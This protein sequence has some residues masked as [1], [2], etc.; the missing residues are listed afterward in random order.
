MIIPHADRATVDIRK[1]REY[2]LDPLHDEGKHKAR[3]FA[4]ALGMTA[5]DAEALRE[6]LLQAIKTHDAYLGYRDAFGQRYMVDFPLEWQARQAIVRSGW[7]IEHG[8]DAPRL[9]SCYVL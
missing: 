5:A 7:I 1:L 6:I 4:A 9:T 8:S 2:C 3:V